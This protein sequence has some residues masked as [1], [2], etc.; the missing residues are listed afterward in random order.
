MG[1]SA[2]LCRAN[3]SDR[4]VFVRRHHAAADRHRTSMR[5]NNTVKKCTAARGLNGALQRT[6]AS[7]SGTKTANRADTRPTTN[8]GEEEEGM[9][10]NADKNASFDTSARRQRPYLENVIGESKALRS[11]QEETFSS[12][13]EHSRSFL[14][15]ARGQQEQPNIVSSSTGAY[16]GRTSST[17]PRVRVFG[18]PMSPSSIACWIAKL[19]GR[20]ANVR[21]SGDSKPLTA[22]KHCTADH[23]LRRTGRRP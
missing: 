9:E 14:C 2:Y 1:N 16:H 8:K 10:Q 7:P 20:S 11:T 17:E 12:D 6:P 4:V 18:L 5:T 3:N 19:H 23:R 15:L 21:P 13:T 22:Q